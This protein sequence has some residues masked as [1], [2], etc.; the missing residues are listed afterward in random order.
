MYIDIEET[1]LKIK[2]GLK[3]RWKRM[4]R[5]REINL[6]S[7]GVKVAKIKDRDAAFS[8]LF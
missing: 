3:L 6:V 5:G 8:K 1:G 2:M 7:R 4:Y